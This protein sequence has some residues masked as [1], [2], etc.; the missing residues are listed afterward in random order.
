MTII[1]II[2][3]LHIYYCENIHK[4]KIVAEDDATLKFAKEVVFTE[5]LFT[6]PQQNVRIILYSRAEINLKV[7]LIPR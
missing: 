4:V 5:S 3:I 6:Q 2:T 1:I 7:V